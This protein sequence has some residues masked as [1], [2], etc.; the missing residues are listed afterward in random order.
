[1]SR[2]LGAG[3]RVSASLCLTLAA[4]A[5]AAAVAQAAA[6]DHDSLYRAFEAVTPDSGRVAAVRHLVLTRGGTTFELDSGT[7][8]L[9]API[10]GRTV[11][12]VYVGAGRVRFTPPPGPERAHLADFVGDTAL[13]APIRAIAFY[14]ADSTA[15]ELAHR[16]RFAPGAVPDGGRRVLAGALDYVREHDADTYDPEFFLPFLN[17]RTT[18]MFYAH[19]QRAGAGPVIVVENPMESE[20]REIRAPARKLTFRHGATEDASRSAAEDRETAALRQEVE[21]G[22]TVSSYDLDVSLPR[23]GMGQVRFLAS[24]TMTVV[25]PVPAGPWIALDLAEPLI[26]DS[27]RLGDGRPAPAYKDKDGP[28]F[29]VRLDRVLEPGETAKV[30]AFYHGDLIQRY[31]DWFFIQSTTAWYPRPLNGRADAYFK[32]TFHT[33]DSY[34]FVAVGH[35]T[36]STLAGHT[37]TTTWVTP[38]SIRNFGFNL[39]LFRSAD[40]PGIA[41]PRVTVLSSEGAS[42]SRNVGTDVGAALQFFTATFGPLPY[43]RLYVTEIPY[44]HGEAFP[45]LIHLSAL[46]FYSPDDPDFQTLFRAHEVAHQWFG[47]GVDFATYHDQWLSEGLANYAALWLV[48][49]VRRNNKGYFHTLDDWKADLNARR[50]D[51][52][53]VWLGW[54]NATPTDGSEYDL[55]VYRK[56]AWVAHMLRILMLDLQTMDDARFTAGLRDFYQTFR[57][58]KAST[59]DFRLVMERHAGGALGWFSDEWLKTTAMPS[60]RVA[61]RAEP[62][63]GGYRVQL[64]IQQ[65]GVPPTFLM[66]VPVTVKLETG[67]MLR[68]RVK[69]QGP[70]TEVTLPEVPSKPKD[71]VFN[72]L[73]GV[74]ANVSMTGW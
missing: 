1:M 53:P 46:T 16:L 43:D 20:D 12:A 71:L 73:D 21:P 11:A 4:V 62:S 54:R 37:V 9:A 27:V 48:Q 69:V 64:R 51:I 45:G 34:R 31:E 22:P 47:V 60:Y 44:L 29:W 70:V 65:S 3:L 13:D 30:T 67:G 72:D 2:S 39:G 25:S 36:D 8:A 33:P 74:L 56:G 18:G 59:D 49:A 17:G 66:Y 68:A 38:D 35:R 61:W 23:N 57:G 14:F 40:V 19:V 58:R 15:D 24:A 26:V 10:A 41:A 6:A 42:S 55:A 50:N 5:P 63:A 32:A 28:V 52:G 7:L